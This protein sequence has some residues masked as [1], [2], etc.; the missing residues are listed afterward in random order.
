MARVSRLDITDARSFL[1][2]VTSNALQRTFL[3][4]SGQSTGTGFTI[5]LDSG[6]YLL[7]AKQVLENAAESIEIFHNGEWRGFEVEPTTVSEPDVDAIAL[8]LSVR[9]SP[10]HPLEP[11]NSFYVSQQM[12]FLGFPFGLF[13]DA[14]VHITAFPSRL[15]RALLV[16]DLAGRLLL[17]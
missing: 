13:T 9:I 15:L 17:G 14:S 16:R 11:S 4:R 3:I 2:M 6:H 8:R 7:T 1:S 12:F 5:D 10:N